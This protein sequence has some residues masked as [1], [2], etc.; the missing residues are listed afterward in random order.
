MKH[1]FCYPLFDERKCV[2]RFGYEL[3]QKFLTCNKLLERFDYSG[4]GESSGKYEDITVDTI[5]EDTL[6]RLVFS[7]NVLIGVRFGATVAMMVAAKKQVNNLVLI[8]PVMD[9]EEYIDQ[10]H[11]QQKLKDRLSGD[12]VFELHDKEFINLEG[13]KTSVKFLEQIKNFDIEKIS[14]K[15]KARNIN[16]ILH[17]QNRNKAKQINNIF[18]FYKLKL[19]IELLDFPQFWQRIPI[20][21]YSQLTEMI[22]ERCNEK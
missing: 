18:G 2:H 4:T 7:D 20:R 14:S 17:N 1:I 3:S 6:D 10:L 8:E 11:R 13:Y 15:V 22:L 21:K 16:I 5:V 9:G 19:N 12:G